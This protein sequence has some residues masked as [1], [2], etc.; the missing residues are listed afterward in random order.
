MSQKLFS[1][2]NKGDPVLIASAYELNQ[3]FDYYGG[4]TTGVD[5]EEIANQIGTIAWIPN[6]EELNSWNGTLSVIIPNGKVISLPFAALGEVPT[7]S[8]QGAVIEE[9][10]DSDEEK[11]VEVVRDKASEYGMV[12]NLAAETI[13]ATYR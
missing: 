4:N 6:K 13:Q 12:Q 3:F 2:Y 10:D 11:D 7:A 5:V 8:S 9:P 1:E